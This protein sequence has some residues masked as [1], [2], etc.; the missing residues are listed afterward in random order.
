VAVE[1]RR[2]DDLDDAEGEAEARELVRRHPFKLPTYKLERVHVATL[3]VDYAPPHGQGYAR[4]LSESRLKQLRVE[5]DPLAVSPLTISRR[6]D[7]T[8]FVIDGN[9][10]RVVAYEKGMLQLPAMVHSGLE[11]AQE[12]DLYVKLGTVLGQTPWT[13]FRSKLVAGDKAALHIVEIAA[14]HDLEV[15]GAYAKADGKIQA[16]ARIEWIYARGGAEALDWVLGF[17]TTAFGPERDAYGEMQLEGILG[18]WVRYADKVELTEVARMVGAVGLNAW[19]DRAASIWQRVDVGTRGNTFGLAVVDIVNDRWR[20]QG[21]KVKD[22]LPAWETNIGAF[23]SRLRPVT[24]RD[25][26]HNWT[27]SSARNPAPQQL[28]MAQGEMR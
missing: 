8:L 19:Y 14:K 6:P 7:N 16:V 2:M 10:R 3:N 9:H 11:R 13:R 28:S 15:N 25:V 5:W 27:T 20:K 18:F 26:A 4:P 12:A 22:L 17:L 21:K 23:G 1:Q 24:F